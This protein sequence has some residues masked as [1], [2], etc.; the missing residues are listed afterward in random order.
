MVAALTSREGKAIIM[1]Q[2][3]II[4]R[5]TAALAAA[6]CLGI[7]S[8]VPQQAEAAPVTFAFTGA[9]TQTMFDP[10]DPSGGEI[11]AG[12]GFS[13]SYTFES[14]ASDQIPGAGGAY[15]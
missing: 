5:L 4:R 15:A 11:T 10:N 6:V 8:P 2:D 3:I 9:V 13:G 1:R 7:A 12:T 14:T